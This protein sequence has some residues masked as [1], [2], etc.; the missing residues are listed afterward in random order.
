MIVE[1]KTVKGESVNFYNASSPDE[2]A[3]VNGMRHF[4]FSFAGRDDDDNIVIGR[5]N[6]SSLKY[7]LLH[8]IEFNSDRKR[9]SVIVRTEDGQILL[10]CKGAD[11]IINARLAPDQEFVAETN[12][13]LDSFAE[14][15]MRTLL[16]A[17]KYINESFYT[18]WV[19]RF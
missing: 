17:Y 19:K 4:G 11:S 7:K 15:G 1:P 18:E 14:Q 8:I 9:M 16:I 13:N 6:R 5:K 12:K 3:L 10:V 2:L